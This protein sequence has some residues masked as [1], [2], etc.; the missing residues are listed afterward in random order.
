MNLLSH[1]RH[2][3]LLSHFFNSFRALG[4]V[5]H[6]H[7][8]KYLLWLFFEDRLLDCLQEKFVDLFLLGLDLV[9]GKDRRRQRMLVVVLRAEIL[10]RLPVFDSEDFVVEHNLQTEDLLLQ[11]RSCQFFLSHAL[12]KGRLLIEERCS[13]RESTNLILLGQQRSLILRRHH[14]G[15]DLI[16]HHANDEYLL[17]HIWECLSEIKNWH[18]LLRLEIESTHDSL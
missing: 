13:K 15:Q 5:E 9:F 12:L 14:Y 4:K 17:V 8:L 10:K 3:K 1:I 11:L 16:V 7:V 18:P 6:V 2:F